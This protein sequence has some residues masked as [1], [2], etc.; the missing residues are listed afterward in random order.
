MRGKKSCIDIYKITQYV[1]LGKENKTNCEQQETDKKR[2]N[3]NT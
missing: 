3:K 1:Y 2:D